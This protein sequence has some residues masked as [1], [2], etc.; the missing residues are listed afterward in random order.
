MV[1]PSVDKQRFQAN[2]KHATLIHFTIKHLT[3]QNISPLNYP[4]KEYDRLIKLPS[5]N[6]NNNNNKKVPWLDLPS[7]Q[8]NTLWTLSLNREPKN[9]FAIISEEGAL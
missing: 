3:L 5:V 1:S 2:G 7:R 9:T 6:N 8:V 4:L